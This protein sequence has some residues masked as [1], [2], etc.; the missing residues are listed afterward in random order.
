MTYRA[1]HH[2]RH[3]PLELPPV[4]IR[5]FGHMAVELA[6]DLVTRYPEAP[7]SEFDTAESLVKEMALPPGEEPGSLPSLLAAFR[8]A[9][10]H[11][12]DTAG[13]GYLAYIPAGGLASSAVADMLSQIANR[14]TGVAQLAPALVAMERGVLTWLCGL[15]G[16]PKGAGGLVTTGGSLAT[17]SAVVTARHHRLGFDLAGARLYVTEQTHYCVAKAA[18]VAG[19]PPESVRTVPTTPALGMDVEAAAHMIADDRAA[20]LR[21]FLLVG[22]AGTTNTGAVDPLA[23]LAELTRAEDLWF[24]VDAAYGGGFQ[25]T[26]YGKARF[27]GI[28]NAD[29]IA[30]DPHKSLFLPYGTGVLLVRDPALLG[31]AHAGDGVYLQD[32]DAV[33]GL[34]DYAQLGPELTRDAR[35][36]RLWLPLH[37]HGVKAFREA[38][39]EKL[40]LTG[41]VYLGLAADSRFEVPWAPDLTV[42]AFRLRDR[43]DEANE[44]LL[45]RINASKRVFLSSTT[46][47]GRFYLRVCVLSHRT[48]ADRIGELLEIIGACAD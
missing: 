31:A 13:P 5:E 3:Y 23:D 22:T 28:H 6:A 48:H 32:L 45:R 27:A 46:I 37:L 15:F 42:V 41:D 16:L 1:S 30:L 12:V 29:S 24:H 11:G 10:G 17:L 8:E 38:L 35:G 26:R 40:A 14:F 4:D 20:G 43:D 25:L 9:V 39:E 36:M 18:A 34:P 44:E 47:N 7:A 33:Y 21:P 19:L 2:S